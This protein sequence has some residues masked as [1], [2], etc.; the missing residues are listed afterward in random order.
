MDEWI[1]LEDRIIAY[2]RKQKNKRFETLSLQKHLMVEFKGR[3][4]YKIFADAIARLIKKGTFLPVKAQ[5]K[6][7][8]DPILY[9]WHQFKDEKHEMDPAVLHEIEY[10]FEG[11]F[12]AHYY[13]KHPE[14]Y[15]ADRS[16]LLA[17]KTY[18]GDRGE[19]KLAVNERMYQLFD[20]EKWLDKNAKL[21]GRINISEQDL[22]CSIDLEPFLF[23]PRKLSH[24]RTVN[25]LIIE[26]KATFHSLKK[27]VSEG[28]VSF[29]GLEF[30]LLIFGAGNQIVGSFPYFYELEP[31][32][33]VDVQFYYFGDLDLQGV[34]IW[35]QL[36]KRNGLQTEPFTFFYE[37][38]LK[39]NCH[40]WRDVEADQTCSEEGL[41][42]FL[43]F[44]CEE[45]QQEVRERLMGRMSIQQEGLHRTLL[46]GLGAHV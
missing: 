2:L 21:L 35:H 30:H 14:T 34:Y 5:G 44:F 18:L 27:L 22:G 12:S 25:A 33:D 19:E 10:A 39:Y 41:A 15:A 37:A 24:H 4:E 31:Y 38:L 32:K 17:I 46:R 20:D 6:N 42:Q 45:F 3:L 43:S 11:Y 8:M 7:G 40:R 1:E 28:S 23:F 29:G 26:N 13:V 9:R 36:N 16:F